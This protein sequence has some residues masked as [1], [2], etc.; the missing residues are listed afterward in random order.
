VSLA[1]RLDRHDARVLTPLPHGDPRSRDRPLSSSPAVLYRVGAREGTRFALQ[2]VPRPT[3]ISAL[4]RKGTG[5]KVSTRSRCHRML[6]KSRSLPCDGP[7]VIRGAVRVQS[8]C[9]RRRAPWRHDHID[10]RR[11]RP[12]S[13]PRPGPIRCGLQPPGLSHVATFSRAFRTSYRMSPGGWR[14]SRS[15]RNQAL[16]ARSVPRRVSAFAPTATASRTQREPG[17]PGVAVVP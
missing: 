12:S 5:R 1:A 3:V 17:V 9:T 16:A 6:Q 8:S 4:T 15:S 2:F 14:A 13:G 11:P 10:S 7:G